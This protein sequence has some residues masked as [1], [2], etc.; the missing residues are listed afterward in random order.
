MTMLRRGSCQRAVWQTRTQPTKGSACGVTEHNP[1]RRWYM[2]TAVGVECLMQM[3][4]GI[5]LWA[6]V[7]YDHDT[8]I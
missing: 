1:R 3:Q 4:D 5:N 2:G 6:M 8:N 7:Y